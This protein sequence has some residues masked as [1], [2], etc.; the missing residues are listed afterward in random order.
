ML[1]GGGDRDR[2]PRHGSLPTVSELERQQAWLLASA[3]T[4]A[5]PTHSLT[6]ARA[7]RS[8]ALPEAGQLRALRGPGDARRRGGA[9]GGAC[10]GRPEAGF[11]IGSREALQLAAPVLRLP[12]L[13]PRVGGSD[14]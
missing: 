6:S 8:G 4:P 5:R 13:G 1:R 14:H 2:R 11:P 7:T 3:T 10:E 12:Q 9:R